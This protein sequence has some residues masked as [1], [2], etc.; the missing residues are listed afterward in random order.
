MIVCDTNQLVHSKL[1]IIELT[2]SSAAK[3]TASYN[4]RS[5]DAQDCAFLYT[6]VCH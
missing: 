3:N 2:V 6:F 4:S 1:G 5:A